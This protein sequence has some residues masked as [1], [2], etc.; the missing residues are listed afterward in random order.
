MEDAALAQH[1][2]PDIRVEGLTAA[3][4]PSQEHVGGS[5]LSPAPH[6]PIVAAAGE[7]KPPE[8]GEHIGKL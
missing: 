3:H 6:Q 8:E 2:H 4:G 1:D 5:R 7:A